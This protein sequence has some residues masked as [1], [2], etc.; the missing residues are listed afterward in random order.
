[1]NLN[2]FAVRVAKLEGGKKN[3]SIAQIKEVIKIVFGL[4][5]K[6]GIDIPKILRKT[7]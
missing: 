1:M 7:K 4:I 3:L 6:E 2:E 5:L